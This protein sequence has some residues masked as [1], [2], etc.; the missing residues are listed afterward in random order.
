MEAQRA[1]VHRKEH[2]GRGSEDERK[3]ILH[4]STYENLVIKLE[5]KSL[6]YD[7]LAEFI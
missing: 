6:D 1:G 5:L 4:V 2:Q 7:V 3:T